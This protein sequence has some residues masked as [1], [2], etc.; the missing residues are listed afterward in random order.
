M[1]YIILKHREDR[2]GNNI[3]NYI[4][5]INYAHKNNY[6]IVY[7]KKNIKYSDSIFIQ[8]LIEK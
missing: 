3:V 2:L 5:Q 6:G 1:S 8:F 7:D 4:A